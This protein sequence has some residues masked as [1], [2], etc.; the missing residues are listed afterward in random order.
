MKNFILSF[1][2][3][4]PFWVSA[5]INHTDSNGLRQGLWKKEYP[6]GRL[7]YEG[8]FRDGKPVGGWK[9][10]HESGQVKAIISYHENSDSA[11]VQLFD[12]WGKK[13]TEGNYIGEK[14]AGVWIL[15]SEN[16]K[17]AEENYSGGVKCGISRK[18][19]QT[20][21]VLE[22]SE[23]QNGVQEGKYQVFFKNGKPFMQCKFSNN[24]RNGLFL[25]YFQNGRV[26]LEAYYKNNLRD[27]EWKYFSETGDYIYSLKYDNGTLL[28]PAVRDSIDNL[29][30]QN[31]ESGKN[32]IL[33]PEK[34][35]QDPSEYMMKMKIYQ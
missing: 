28:N 26:E 27:S 2:I 8:N 20:G 25:S 21:E 5:Q 11:F 33:D 13:V 6:N 18:F 9:R 32:S 4:L 7:M 16:R 24:Q 22:E 15:F 10:Y 35:M 31:I 19:Y 30:L 1:L 29:Q 12:E 3:F 34:F 17:V 14:K 23:W